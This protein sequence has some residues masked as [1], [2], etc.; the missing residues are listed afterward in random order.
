MRFSLGASRG[1]VMA[2]LLTEALILSLAGAALGIGVASAAS[3][4]LRYLAST[5]PRIEE[6]HL[7]WRIVFYTLVVSVLAALACGLLP[8][9]RAT[10]R[11]LA[12]P[13]AQAGRAHVAGR[14]QVQLALVGV[15]VAL[16]VA[17]LSGAGLLL[18]S[19]QELGR[20]SPGFDPSHVL[21]F[22]ISTSWA[23]T[24]DGKARAQRLDRVLDGLRSIA[25]AESAAASIWLPGMPNSYQVE[26][27][28][29]EGRAETEPK[30]MG[31]SRFVSAG[32]FA[33]MRIPLLAG[34]MCREHST[35]GQVM[36]NRRFAN[37]YLNGGAA[38]GRHLEEPGDQYMKPAVIT[39]IVGDAR[40]LGLDREPEPTVYWCGN[41]I[42]PGSYFVLRTRGDARALSSTVRR[43]IQ[44]VEPRRS[45]YNLAPLTDSISDSYAENRMRTILLAFFAATAIGLACVGLYGTLSYLVSIRQREVGLRLALGALRGQIVRQ[46]VNQGLRI[47]IAGCAAGI[48]LSAAFTRLLA[49]MLF[50]VSPWDAPTLAGVIALALAVSAIASLL[51]ALRA[52]RLEPMEVLREE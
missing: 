49:G 19:F 28:A 22:Q 26:L 47:S 5:L 31:E 20:V 23:E 27:R 38:L 37:A 8:A 42:Q 34:D 9:I 14:N 2:Q 7:D 33:A 43:K 16:A 13:I 15:Q 30:M 40:E 46:F 50:G 10:R 36:V 41:P 48:A 4:I 45:V 35:V 24:N 6:I 3:A 51:P 39:G 52:A 1:S 32:Y 12:S 18:R 21:A 25:G 29:V 11:D 17:L 44:E